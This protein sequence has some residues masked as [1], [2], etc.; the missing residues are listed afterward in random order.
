V[1]FEARGSTIKAILTAAR[2]YEIPRFQRD[3]SW[4]KKNYDEFLNDMLAQISFEGSQFKNSQYYLGSMLFFGEVNSDKVEVVDG[5]QRLTTITILFAALRNS[6]FDASQREQDEPYHYAATIQNEYLIKNIDGKPHRKLQTKT[7]YPYF[8][9][10]IQDYD[11]RN[12]DVEPKT[13]EEEVL[14]S[15]FDFFIEKLKKENLLSSINSLHSIN[16]GDKCYIELLKALRDQILGS[17]V[18]EIFVSDKDQ[19]NRI[20][21][22]INSKG[23]PLTQVDL[24]KNLIFKK[25]QPT[26]GG[27]DEIYDKWNKFTESINKIDTNFNEFF[28]HFWKSTYPKDG[29]N[30]SNLY[31]KYIVKYGKAS[32]DQI[33]QLIKDLEESLNIYSN[34]ISP[35]ENKY[36]KQEKKPELKFLNAITNFRGTQVRVALLSLYRYGKKLKSDERIEI[37]KFL[38]NFHFAAFGTNLRIRSNQTTG[39]YK[40]FAIDILQAND[41]LNKIKSAIDKLKRSLAGLLKEDT[42]KESFTELTFS[43]KGDSFS[44][45]TQY[46]IK[47]ILN[48]M[49]EEKN[50]D[51]CSIEHILDE[52]YNEKNCNI[53]NLVALETKINLD[54]NKFKQRNSNKI[55][56]LEKKKFYLESRYK[57]VKLLVDNYADF[58][59]LDIANRAKVLADYFWDTFFKKYK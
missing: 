6:L 36:K 14:K 10:T 59:T 22:N 35:D 49:N 3:F 43:K 40:K 44:F 42:F 19:V 29:V 55:S 28:L 20:F 23:K 30:G 37:L 5:Q 53:G 25:I 34:I 58:T 4:D 51:D 41:D 1:N 21:E 31:D 45:A 56:Y 39:L 2:V 46:A 48:S 8:T 24:I 15:A 26:T 17:E 54:I 38:S 57:M 27:V 7:S 52:E 12:L 9:Q 33:R 11:E 16:V 50:I 32:T 47:Q 18:I 13:E